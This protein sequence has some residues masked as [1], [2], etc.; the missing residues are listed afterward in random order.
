M[1][2]WLL[3]CKPVCA[4]VHNFYSCGYDT[5]SVALMVDCRLGL[6]TVLV[7]ISTGTVMAECNRTLT[8]TRYYQNCEREKE[9]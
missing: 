9:I 8:A 6:G 4:F 1:K 2:T 7:L 5:R 3:K